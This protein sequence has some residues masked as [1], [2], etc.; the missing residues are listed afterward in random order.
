VPAYS[1]EVT[2]RSAAPPE[3][4]FALL[5]DALTWPQWAGPVVA[6]AS[7]VSEGNPPPGGVG[8]VRKVGRRPGYG[9]E[10]VV[11]WEP[12]K[13]Y[14]YTMLKGNPVKNYRADV[15]LIADGNGTKITWGASLEPKIP[16]TG[17]IVAAA[18]RRLIG[19]FAR[20]LAAYAETQ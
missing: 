15:Y 19:S 7:W 10:Q 1:Y 11:A 2:A 8:A 13:H 6:E 17:R 3:K 4:V 18:Y 9:Y 20:K 12:P 5:S 14:A 16:G